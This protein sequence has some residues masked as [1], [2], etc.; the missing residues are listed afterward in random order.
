MERLDIDEVYFHRDF[1]GVVAAAVLLRQAAGEPRLIP[2]DYDLKDQWSSMPVHSRS[3]VVDFLFHPQSGYWYDHHRD[4]FLDPAWKK[5]FRPSP[6]LAWEPTAPSCPP[7][8][9]AALPCPKPVR[10]HFAQYVRWS[11]I[12]DSARYV[13][14]Q[15][16]TDLSIPYLRLS[17]A[18]ELA[19]PDGL[20]EVVSAVSGRDVQDVLRLAVLQPYLAKIL[21]IERDELV[22]PDTGV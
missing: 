8:I 16:A 17:R 20:C 18:L 12:I 4:P 22:Q 14:P 15:Q 2:V 5:N 11:S 19:S 3:A 13:S 9:L 1:D 7:V 10:R 21:Q 6:R